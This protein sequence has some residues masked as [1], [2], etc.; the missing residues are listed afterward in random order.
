MEVGSV[1]YRAGA[2]AGAGGEGMSGMVMEPE[3]AHKPGFVDVL[4]EGAEGVRQ[5][6]I[7]ELSLQP[8]SVSVSES[9][10]ESVSESAPESVNAPVVVAGAGA[11]GA[12]TGTSLSLEEKL[13]ILNGVGSPAQ[14]EQVREVLGSSGLTEDPAQRQQLEG[15]VDLLLQ[16]AE[17]MPARTSSCLS[18]EEVRTKL[19]LISIA[20][21]ELGAALKTT[22]LDTMNPEQLAKLNAALDSSQQPR[23]TTNYTEVDISTDFP[24]SSMLKY[25]G[26]RT[27]AP[28]AR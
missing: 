15:I 13:Q 14:L 25:F 4:W 5:T 17:G 9:A 8:V 1:V 7:S 18:L 28:F 20:D 6:S 16:D 24:D 10:P 12:G 3:V 21:P 22:N 2:G 19:A 23:R 11:G 27:D 26:Q